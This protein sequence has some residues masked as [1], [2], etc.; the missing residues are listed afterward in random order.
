MGL[1]QI[2]VKHQGLAVQLKGFIVLLEFTVG[3]THVVVRHGVGG[4]LLEDA[5]KGF[6]GFLVFSCFEIA[7]ALLILCLPL[8]RAGLLF[9]GTIPRIAA[10][11]IG[12][13]S[14]GS[15]QQWHHEQQTTTQD[16]TPCFSCHGTSSSGSRTQSQDA[17][18]LIIPSAR[19]YALAIALDVRFQVYCDHKGGLQ[20]IVKAESHKR[21]CGSRLAGKSGSTP[22]NWRGT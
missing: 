20:P 9:L 5:F 21:R 14:V 10:L 2:G 13:T 11:A 6:N 19:I 16:H 8:D 22:P 3:V 12:T 17:R 15:C 4:I 1:S 18:G 7:V